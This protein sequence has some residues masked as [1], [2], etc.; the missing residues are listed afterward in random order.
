MCV[1]V[2]EW[3]T[4]APLPGRRVGH[5]QSARLRRD[6]EGQ[7]WNAI[8]WRRIAAPDRSE[9]NDEGNLLKK[10]TVPRHSPMSCGIASKVTHIGRTVK[11]YPPLLFIYPLAMIDVRDIEGI[12]IVSLG[13]QGNLPITNR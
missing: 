5:S 8:R 12:H 6:A 2:L 4:A 1:C 10:V 11:P 3:L 13:V 7:D 9:L